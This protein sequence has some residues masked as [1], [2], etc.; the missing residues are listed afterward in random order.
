[1][2][3]PGLSMNQNELPFVR[4]MFDRIAP[5]YDLLNRLLS[6]RRD[7]IWRKKLVSALGLKPGARVL[8]AACGTADV[9]LQI[10][11]AASGS[12]RVVGVDFAAEMLRLAQHKIARRNC[13]EPIKLAVADA[14]QL[15]FG[16]D[17]F[18][19]VSMAFGIRNIQNKS[20]V[21]RNFYHHL[22]PGGH[23]AILELA[24]PDAG[25]LQVAYLY[26]VNRILPGVGRLF[27]KHHFA[28][29]YLPSSVAAFPAAPRFADL[30]RQAGFKRVRYLKL[31][32]GVAVLFV[33]TKP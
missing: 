26:Y 4:E 16:A 2:Q 24:T 10:A 25:F 7:V 1:M 6:L 18:D 30:M 14:L 20:A 28:Y 23:L 5:R 22:K 31:T 3:D 33:G 8:D 32:L 11:M 15:P 29:T 21:L 17:R 9:A 13:A 19:A 27:S 12:V